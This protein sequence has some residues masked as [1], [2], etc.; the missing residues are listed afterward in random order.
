MSIIDSFARNLSALMSAHPS[1][2]SHSR[3]GAAAGLGPTNI[4]RMKRGEVAAQIDTV[5]KIAKAF[6]LRACDILDPEL[7]KRIARG[8]VL[9]MGEHR[10]PVI[11]EKDWQALSPRTR[12]LVEDLCASSLA[13]ALQDDDIAWLHDAMQRT[14]R[15]PRR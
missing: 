12:A 11:P 4:G 15:Q 8:E 2:D 14:S 6:R 7:S 13:G 3:L 10:P 1:L 9:R 5:E